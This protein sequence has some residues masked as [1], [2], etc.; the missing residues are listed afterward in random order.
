MARHRDDAQK[1]ESMQRIKEEKY[2]KTKIA[3]EHTRLQRRLD[4]A[5][6]SGL[7]SVIEYA[8]KALKDFE[9]EYNL[10]NE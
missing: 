7:K 4:I 10:K 8:V 3:T 9:T 6:E 5:L 1:L 2:Q